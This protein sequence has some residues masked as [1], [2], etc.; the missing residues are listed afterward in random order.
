MAVPWSLEEF[1][2]LE[3]VDC[4]LKAKLGGFATKDVVYEV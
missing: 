3:V 2:F 4:N 1:M